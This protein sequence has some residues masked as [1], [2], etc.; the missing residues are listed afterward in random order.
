VLAASV[1]AM[2]MIQPASTSEIPANF[3]DTTRRNT[4]EIISTRAAV[5]TENLIID[6]ESAGRLGTEEEAQGAVFWSSK[7]RRICFRKQV[8]WVRAWVLK[9]GWEQA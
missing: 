1:R 7:H 3:Y 9:P 4:P 6:F 5:R 2:M 8:C